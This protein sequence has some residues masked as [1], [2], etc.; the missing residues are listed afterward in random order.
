MEGGAESKETISWNDKESIRRTVADL[1]K[2]YLV[3]LA[4]LFSRETEQMITLRDVEELTNRLTRI[5]KRTVKEISRPARAAS[6]P[7]RASNPFEREI[8]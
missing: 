3:I 1:G 7:S 4:F 2:A 6:D 5:R 8:M